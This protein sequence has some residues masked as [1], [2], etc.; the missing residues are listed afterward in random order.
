VTIARILVGLVVAGLF[1][2]G[3]LYATYLLVHRIR[4]GEP[5]AKS[6]GL[7]LRDLFDAATGL[8]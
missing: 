1:V 3:V 8:G 6:F 2:F 5:R 4:R 7:W